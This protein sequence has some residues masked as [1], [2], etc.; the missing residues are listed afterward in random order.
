MTPPASAVAGTTNV[1]F[2]STSATNASTGVIVSDTKT[3]AVTVTAAATYSATLTPNNNGQVSPG[4]TVVYPHTLNN[5]GAQACGAYT[6]STTQS[7][8]AAGWTVALFLDVNGNGVIDAGDTPVTG[9]IAGPLAAGGSQKILVRVFAPGGATAGQQDT[10]VVTATFAALGGGTCG[11]SSATDVSTV[12]TGQIRV[13]KNQSIDADCNGIADGAFSAALIT[14]AKPGQCVVYR[15]I[16]TNEGTA[17]ITNLAINDALP[18][19][20]S[21]TGAIQPAAQCAASAGVT[22]TAPVYASTGSTV[23]CGSA[24]NSVAP[25]ATLQLS[26]AVRINP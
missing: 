24:A 7:A 17:A 26:F 4:G 9:A 23:S 12:V 19:Y 16:A 1:Y 11:P 3:D 15:V 22:G 21:L 8:A 14:G 2:R 10:L 20:T 13:V 5:T 25:G 18:N 6:L